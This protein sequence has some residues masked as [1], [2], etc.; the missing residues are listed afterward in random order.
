[1]ISTLRYRDRILRKEG[2]R[3]DNFQSESK[4]FQGKDNFLW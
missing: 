1:M 4:S 2:S 3:L